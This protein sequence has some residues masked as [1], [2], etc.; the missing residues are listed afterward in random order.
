MKKLNKIAGLMMMNASPFIGGLV[1]GLII[2][3][4]LMYFGLSNGIMVDMFCPAK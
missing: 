4:I 1:V 3:I 2:G